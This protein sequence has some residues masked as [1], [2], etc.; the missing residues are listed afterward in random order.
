MM[1]LTADG[2]ID[3]LFLYY[4]D[5]SIIFCLFSFLRNLFEVTLAFR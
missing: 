3:V 5:A 1:V 2:D 4:S